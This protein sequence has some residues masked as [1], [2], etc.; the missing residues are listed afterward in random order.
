MSRSTKNIVIILAMSVLPM[1]AFQNCSDVS[2][3]KMAGDTNEKTGLIA[4]LNDD[5]PAT[6]IDEGDGSGNDDVVDNNDD[7][8]TPN[9][10]SVSNDDDS[11]DDG[12]DD[13]VSD[14]G[15]DDGSDDGADDGSDDSSDDG[16]DNNGK[17]DDVVSNDDGGNNA[18]PNDDGA[19]DDLEAVACGEK[20]V[21]ICHVPP[22]NPAAR[23][24]ICIGKPALDAHMSHK[25]KDADDE[26]DTLG[27]CS[28]Q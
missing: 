9:D 19:D 20:K 5:V 16:K 1:F 13:G 3:A 21:M 23:H 15:A 14:D 8:T 25:L 26:T 27:A 22:G 28:A 4:D 2:F 11:S 7:D 10:D 12:V 24:T 17:K 6:V 18:T